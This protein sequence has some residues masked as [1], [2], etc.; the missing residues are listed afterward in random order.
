MLESILY[1][2][3]ENLKQKH[4][5]T[6]YQIQELQ[7]SLKYWYKK[8]LVYPS[9]LKSKLNV[10]I[11]K[12]YEILEDIKSMGILER[13]Y[14]V[15][16]AKCSHFKGKILRTPTDMDKDLSCDFCNHEF[17]PLN[18]TIMI[19]RVVKEPA[20]LALTLVKTK[21]ALVAAAMGDP[22]NCH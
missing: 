14:E 12:M 16:C 9:A 15:Y 18:D 6:D 4:S 3:I 19:Y 20:W 1:E 7:L 13:N 11:L 10:D 17:D 21:L 8:T 5:L 22:L 2:V